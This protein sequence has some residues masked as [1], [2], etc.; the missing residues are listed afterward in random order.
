MIVQSNHLVTDDSDSDAIVIMNRNHGE[1]RKTGVTSGGGAKH[2]EA[3]A[4]THE[5]M[6]CIVLV[7]IVP[8]T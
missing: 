4:H 5:G 1:P 6:F 7:F 8:K 2:P 3:H